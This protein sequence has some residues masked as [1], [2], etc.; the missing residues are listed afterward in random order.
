MLAAGVLSTL[1]AAWVLN[2]SGTSLSKPWVYS[3]DGFLYESIV[4]ATLENGWFLHNPDLGAPFGQDNHDF[5]ITNGDTLHVLIVKVLGLFLSSAFTVTNAF[6]VVTYLL[7]GAIAFAVMRHAGAT[8]GPALVGSVLFAT[9]PYHFLQG[10]NHLFFSSY[11]AVPLAVLLMLRVAGG[12]PLLGP[13]RR[14]LGT[15]GLCLVVGSA[16]LYYAIFA[17]ILITAAGMLRLLS[18]RNRQGLV[19]TGLVLAALG[20]VVMLNQA[21]TLLYHARYGDNSS[22]AQRQPEESEEY[23]LKL[24]AMV[25]PIEGHRIQALA[26]FGQR[27]QSRTLIPGEAESNAGLGLV[28]I[29][30]LVWLFALALVAPAGRALGTLRDRQLSALTVTAFLVATL[31]GVSSVIAWTITPQ[32]RVWS[33]MSIFIGFMSLLAV[34][35]LLSRWRARR[36]LAVAGLA[37]VLVLGVLDQTTAR[38]TPDYEA[39]DRQYAADAGF[40]HELERELPAGAMILTLPYVE[41]PESAFRWAEGDYQHLR[42]YLSST[43]LRWSY[44]A[45]KGRPQDWHGALEE[46]PLRTL[47]DAA[48]AGGFSGVWADTLA[49]PDRAAGLRSEIDTLLGFPQ[50]STDRRLLFW[51]LRPY[52]KSLAVSLGPQRL[53][54]MREAGMRPVRPVYGIGFSYREGA[55]GDRWRSVERHA[56]LRLDNPGPVPR[57]MRMSVLL[58]TDAV[59]PGVATLTLPDGTRLEKAIDQKG[60]NL[61]VRFTAPKGRSRITFDTRAIPDLRVVQ[62]RNLVVLGQDLCRDSTNACTDGPRP[63]LP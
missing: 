5:S 59:R 34:A 13:R 4:K 30:G 14:T 10:P 47:L 31:G 35:L 40:V 61:H 11:Y 16:S 15:L 23:G 58:R 48:A 26:D 57:A 49:W 27:Y 19:A 3:W 24:D 44:G 20:A 7:T 51:D 21:P 22:V 28:S 45:M 2:F 38:F 17:L 60:T 8:R 52:A 46:V 54:A 39:M 29:V 1:I 42:G 36:T 53:A 6:L 25:F 18:Q 9:L 12:D 41:Y 33:R 63:Q 62:A 56:E 37:A 50:I 55:G 43:R 32:I